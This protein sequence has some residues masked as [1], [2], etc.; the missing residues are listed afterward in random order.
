MKSKYYYT[1]ILLSLMPNTYYCINNNN[2]NNNIYDVIS[3]PEI[4]RLTTMY[5]NALTMCQKTRERPRNF[6]VFLIK[7]LRN[8]KKY[9]N[10]PEI[11]TS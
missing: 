2:N 1:L 11:N 5:F 6:F 9:P 8:R 7:I 4:D 3:L 10:H